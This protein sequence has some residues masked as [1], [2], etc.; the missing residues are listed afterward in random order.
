MNNL[1]TKILSLLWKTYKFLLTSHINH[2]SPNICHIN[3][4]FYLWEN[5]NRISSNKIC[6]SS[7]HH[8]RVVV[9]IYIWRRLWYPVNTCCRCY[10]QTSTNIY[11]CVSYQTSCHNMYV[12]F[13]FIFFLLFA[14]SHTPHKRIN[15]K[16]C[17]PLLVCWW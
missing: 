4:I 10:H 3:F 13:F 9:S 17:A 14:I 12:F 8:H 6:Y 2:Y 11:V 1:G 15:G 7:H 16:N 5:I